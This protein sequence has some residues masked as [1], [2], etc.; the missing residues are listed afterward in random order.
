MSRIG[1]RYDA[2]GRSSAKDDHHVRIYRWLSKSEAWAH[3]TGNEIK[4]LLYL[5][6][7]DFGD[8]NG[9]ISMSERRLAEGIHVDRKTARKVLRGLQEKGFITCT[10]PGSF[11]AKQSPAAEWRL[12]WK[13]WPDR[14]QP[15]THDYRRWR[16][17]RE[18]PRRENLPFGGEVFPQIVPEAGGSGGEFDPLPNQDRQKTAKADLGNSSPLTLASGSARNLDRDIAA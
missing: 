1:S 5:A 13:S 14:S 10:S 17:P 7:F 18:K 12:T 16:A 9:R 6:S 8:N 3:S 15:P 11:K 4:G 2:K